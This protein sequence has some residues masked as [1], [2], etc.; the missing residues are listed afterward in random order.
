MNVLAQAIKAY[1]PQNVPPSVAEL[2]SYF[3]N[4][5]GTNLVRWDQRTKAVENS[6]IGSIPKI[7][8]YSDWEGGFSQSFD[9][10]FNSITNNISELENI[11]NNNQVDETTLAKLNAINNQINQTQS[12]ITNAINT[13]GK[14]QTIWV[15]DGQPDI[16][17]WNKANALGQSLYDKM[18]TLREQVKELKGNPNVTNFSPLPDNTVQFDNKVIVLGARDTTPSP[19]AGGLFYSGSDEWF[20]GYEN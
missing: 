16:W 18:A 5:L 15:K 8:T 3:T 12:E 4:V 1:T 19:V 2:E 11:I 14:N 10:A 7:Q 6:L 17:D 20:L 9:F 13:A